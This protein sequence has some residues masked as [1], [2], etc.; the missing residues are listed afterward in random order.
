MV[1]RIRA[2][3][4]VKSVVG[5]GRKSKAMTEGLQRLHEVWLAALTQLMWK[6]GESDEEYKARVAKPYESFN[7][8]IASIRTASTETTTAKEAS[9]A[10]AAKTKP[11]SK[12]KQQAKAKTH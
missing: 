10:K 9:P 11:A 4:F 7:E 12:G 8:H 3:S 2:G 5:V 1:S 6:S